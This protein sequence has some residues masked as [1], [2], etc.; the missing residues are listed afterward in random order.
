MKLQSMTLRCLSAVAAANSAVA[1]SWVNHRSALD[2]VNAVAQTEGLSCIQ[3]EAVLCSLTTN[4]Q[5]CT[6]CLQNNSAA[7]M[8]AGFHASDTE[9]FC[10]GMFGQTCQTN[11]EAVIPFQKGSPSTNSSQ[12]REQA[13][14][15][16]K[17]NLSP[18][19]QRGSQEHHTGAQ[20]SLNCALLSGCRVVSRF[21][22]KDS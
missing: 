6:G 11:L 13:R 3:T 15:H 9:A 12:C 22:S 8:A 16:S 14:R 2:S 5:Q 19:A 1:P 20:L 21:R 7:V 17:V 4:H 10:E 18:K